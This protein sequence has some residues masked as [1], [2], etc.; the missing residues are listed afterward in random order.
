ITVTPA[1]GITLSSANGTDAQTVCN[2]SSIIP[3]TYGISNA[4]NASITSGA[5]PAGVGGAFSGNVFTI[6]GTPSPG[7]SGTF[8]YTITTSGGCASATIT[9]SITLQAQTISLTSGVASPS[10]CNNAAMSAITYTIGGTA[11]GAT[12]SGAPNGVTGALVGNIF[13]INGTPNDANGAYNYIITTTGT[14]CAPVT[15]GGTITIQA[16]ATGG[17]LLSTVSICSGGNGTLTLSGQTGTIQHWEYSTN[18]G[19]SW[20]SIANASITLTYTNVTVSTS[21]RVVV[22][23]G[24]GNVNSSIALV[25]IHNYWTGAVSN[26][27]NTGGN[28]ADGLVPSTSC[29]DVTIPAVTTNNPVVSTSTL[30]ITNL[31]IKPTASL[32]V[33]GSGILQIAGTITNTGIFDVSNGT[34]DFNGVSAQSF[35]GSL[36]VGNTLKNL[37]VSNAGG[38]TVS[39]SGIPLNIT[40]V[41]GFGNVGN[42]NLN[43]GDNI[44]LISSASGTAMVGDITNNGVNSGNHF[45]GKVAVERYYP[46][47]RAWRLVT[48]PLSGTGSV[49]NTWQNAGTYISGRGTYVSG[50]GANIATNGLDPSPRNNTS[51]RLGSELAYVPNTKTLSLSGSTGTADNKGF[52]IFV[53]GDRLPG[54][55]LFDAVSS[56]NTTLSSTGALQTGNQQFS[57]TATLGGYTLIGNPYASPV[58]FAKLTLNNLSKKFY[59]FDPNINT[60]QGAYV[61]M[62]ETSPNSGIYYGTPNRPGG[63]TGIIQSSQAFFVKTSGVSPSILFTEKSKSSINNLSLFR[64]MNPTVSQSFRTN[65]Y[66]IDNNGNTVLADGNLAKFDN[67]YNAGVDLEDALKFGN[68]Y[69]TF[70]ILSG[71]TSLAVSFRP[72]LTKE[73]TIYYKFSRAKQLKYQFEFEADN[74]EQDNLAGFIEDKFLN[75]ATPIN[76]NGTTRFYFEGTPDVASRAEDRFKV[77]FKP[78]VVYTSLTANVLNSDI[79]VEWNVASETNIKGYDIERSADGNHFTKV[80][81][82]ASSGNNATSVGYNW[83]DVSPALGYYYYRIRSISNNNVVGYSNV[84]KVKLNKSTPAMYVFP[85]PV[86]E[87]ILHLQMNSMPKGVYGTRLINNLG[88]VLGTS[89]IDHLAGTGT[90]TIEP[91]TRLLSGIYQLEITAPDKK[92][93]SI[94][95][96]VK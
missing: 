94:K 69:E 81:D 37:T 68:V 92:T 36:F 14:S 85:N 61:T 47:R 79:A 60:Q 25:G 13:T 34:L 4:T 30:A 96:I 75:K 57:A 43:T 7:V 66:L 15:I 50:P 16:A 24:C 78:S 80:S 67:S 93:T 20:T 10:V 84:V 74:L 76:M 52:L 17:T 32:T 46:A 70:G 71:K 19:T 87:N 63:Q 72:V 3:I 59:V 91:N 41:L 8:S 26:D 27:W 56:N 18:G 73:D 55:T 77:V 95:V 86:T 29:P 89:Y 64:P 35:S 48:V 31:I 44:V 2:N 65:L 54:P 90:E 38:L 83:L 62:L 45:T 53:R 9:G 23:N 11:T 39:G 33:S 22:G 49:F 82:R 58:D 28:W 6:S 51:L 40:G 21:Y 12:L 88:Q 42:A 1:A 5:L